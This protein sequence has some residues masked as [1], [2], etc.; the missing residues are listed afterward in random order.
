V[1]FSPDGKSLAV[2]YGHNSNAQVGRVKVWDVASG[3]ELEAF[4]GPRGGV[5]AVAFHPGGKRL[6]VAGS[7]VVEVWELGTAHKI[8]ELK[9]H[10]KWVYCVA[11]SPDGKW[12]A[13]GGWDR[14]V[15]LRDAATGV[16]V[17]TVFAQD[18]FVLSLAFSP[19][20]RTL[21]TSSEDR[22]ARLW[23]VPSGR[24]LAAFHGHSDFV[25]AVAFRPDGR[26]VCTGSMDGSIRF[27]GIRTSRP[28]VV[29]HSATVGRLAFRRDGLRV[30]TEA[31]D[32][33]S[34]LTTG[35][36]PL[37]GDV[38]TGLSGTPFEKLPAEFVPGPD[39]FV[40]TT[41][42]PDGK[43]VAQ[44]PS[45]S[46]GAGLAERSKEYSLSS[47]VIREAASGRIVHTLTGHSG[48]VNCMAFSPDSRRL[49][50]ASLDRTLKLWDVETGQDVFTLRGHTAGLTCMAFS[51]DGNQIVTGSYDATARVWNGTPLASNMTAEHDARYRKKVEA[52][53]RLEDA[54]DDLSR[55]KILAGT[56]QWGM[57]AE[58]FARAAAKDPDNL[59]L[60]YQL[61]E[62]LV[63]AGDMR[64]V[65]PACNDM[66][67]RFGNT[68][69]L[70]QVLGVAGFCRLAR[71]AETDPEKRQAVHDMAIANDSNARVL[72]QAKNG[73]WDLISQHLAKTVEDKPDNLAARMWLLLSLLESG[74]IPGYRAAAGKILSRFR[75][76]SDPNSLNN[77]A[78]CCT[79]VP[80]AVADLSVPVQMAEAAVAGYPADQKRFALNTLGA[81]LYRAGRI[82]EAIARLDESVKAGG[83]VG[84][85]QDWVYLGMAHHKKGNH[86]EAT[87][88]LEKVRAHVKNEKI[89][90]S[91]D[92]VEIRF[93][94]KE[95]VILKK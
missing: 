77:A 36:N 69:D 23:E 89:A 15:K 35:W 7:E 83:G 27:W 26:E 51:P 62:A 17:L 91:T 13:T 84:V 75:K 20:S 12:L 40:A 33:E 88:W 58:A 2:G 80:D 32:H 45:S 64:R 21:V 90:F 22:S 39:R 87:R 76:A 54:T 5:I 86:E 3:A 29:E 24:P 25:F 94:L 8:H 74:D 85:P 43:L 38:D 52:L 95:I 71:T 82:D 16:E 41:K 55:A 44:L 46:P 28:V 48:D 50:T 4:T 93:L 6:A 66:L 56:G 47:V 18:G 65:G 57:A 1:A 11:Y 78:W 30:V 53:A 49:A 42:S 9:G 63:Q 72:I 60:R 70:L 67:K 73:Q 19:D 68:G 59:Q 81:A 92:V 10:K 31:D 34:N 61:I 14:T 79:Y 37:T